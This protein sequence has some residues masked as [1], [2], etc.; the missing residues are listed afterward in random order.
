MLKVGLTGGIGSGKTTV[1]AIFEVLNIPVYYADEAAKR[2]MDEDESLKAA[3]KKNFGDKSY[4]QSNLNRKYLSQ[5]VFNDPARLALLNSI[6]H[7]ATIDDAEQWMQK[8]SSPYVIKEAALLFE[9]GSNKNLDKIIG[10]KAPFDLR[11]LR[12]IKRDNVTREE[13]ISRMKKQMDEE[14][15]LTLCDF[16]V[17]N[18][19]MQL[20]I[21][22]V[23]QLH[24]KLLQ[25]AKPA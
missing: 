10:V 25:L 13:I 24:G 11:I 12:A 22:Q 21:P 15:K 3:I 14:A 8:Q 18:D 16:I 20:L 7:P 23:L 4:E 2:L 1:A 5:I 19:E 6:V 9:S 17:V